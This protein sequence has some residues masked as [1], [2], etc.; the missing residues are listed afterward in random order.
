MARQYEK[1]YRLSESDDVLEKLRAIFLD[2][3][4]RMDAVEIVK[5]DFQ[6]GNRL[7][8]DT[9]LK[10]INEDLAQK[11]AAMQ[12]VIDEVNLGFTPD[13]IAETAEKRF[14]SDAEQ[15]SHVEGLAEANNRI[16][17][18]ATSSALGAHTSRTD[19]PHRVTAAQ[20]GTLNTLEIA[21]AISSEVSAASTQLLADIQQRGVPVGTLF[22]HMFPT[23]P[24]GSLALNGQAVTPVYP[25]LRTMILDMGSPWGTA[26]GDPLLPN[27]IE[28]GEFMRAGGPGGLAIGAMQL[29]QMQ[30]FKVTVPATVGAGTGLQSGSNFGA[31]VSTSSSPVSDGTNGTPRVGS[32]TRPRAF[33]GLPCVKAYG[34]VDPEGMADLSELLTAI[35]DKPTA[36]AGVSNADLM[37]PLAVR[38]A[39]DAR[40]KFVREYIS[41]EQ[42]ITVAGLLTVA[43][44]LGALPKLVQT[45]LRC[46]VA[47]AGYSVGDEVLVFGLADDNGAQINGGQLYADASNI[48]VRFSSAPTLYVIIH[49]ATGARGAI[50][51]AN[52]RLIIGAWA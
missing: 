26:A 6:K 42:A 12:E 39:I 40:A 29:D 13:R 4:Q 32:E 33:V 19:N 18:R 23:P 30:G 28:N 25:D 37:S 48:Y 5:E 41:A 34:T 50:A 2:L 45:R 47:D 43:H 22:Y 44:G 17:A 3:D 24:S 15:Q 14:T 21:E 10:A 49:K 20:V 36:E 46:K 1:R 38:W 27:L 16:N 35:A 51:P 11:S 9:L 7:D 8:V 52:W 31:V